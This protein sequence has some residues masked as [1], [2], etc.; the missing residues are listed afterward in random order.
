MPNYAEQ[1]KLYESGGEYPQN[2]SDTYLATKYVIDYKLEIPDDILN[3]FKSKLISENF[4]LPDETTIVE[5]LTGI[6]SGNIILQGPPGTGKTKLTKIICDLFNV[7]CDIVTATS[8]WTTYD[9]IGGYQP[10]VDDEGNE[11]IEG[12][13]G[14]IV[15]S[16]IECC[17]L[18]VAKEK[19]GI[20]MK[21][22]KWAIIDELN[23]SEIDKVFGDLFTVFGSD[24]I[25]KKKLKLWF[26]A[27]EHKRELYVPN[28]FRIIGAIN[29]VDKNFV[30]NLSQGLSRR[31]NLIT[32]NPPSIDKY[33]DEIL[34]IK[35]NIVKRKVVEKLINFKHG[36]IDIAKID[37]LF[38]DDKYKRIEEKSFELIRHIRYY[39][40]EN[41]EWLG[42]LIG[43]AQLIDVL[44]MVIIQVFLQDTI[45][46]SDGEREAQYQI[47]FDMAISDKIVPQME[48]FYFER[49]SLFRDYLKVEFGS[50][51]KC[52]KQ[53]SAFVD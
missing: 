41:N 30:F 51:K 39:E 43:T 20:Q 28:R 27:D 31:F 23:R 53:I 21:Q 5:I 12:K 10:S 36:A 3:V 33:N 15:D 34:N 25:D 26:H 17:N 29:N 19:H 2:Y 47:A 37:V 46:K 50:Y 13:N 18:V 22:A 48:G 9:T 32:I 52:L 4:Y 6:I 40:E 14:K 16:I 1:M 42:L 7:D 35:N 49:L 8:D 44:E 24:D 11:I 38:A 45:G